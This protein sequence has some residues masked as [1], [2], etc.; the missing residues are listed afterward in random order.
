MDLSTLQ[1][2]DGV[3]YYYI[4]SGMTGGSI[5]PTAVQY[6]LA[7]VGGSNPTAVAAAQ[8]NTIENFIVE[9]TEVLAFYGG[10]TPFMNQEAELLPF[11]GLSDEIAVVNVGVEEGLGGETIEIP[12]RRPPTLGYFVNPF[13]YYCIQ[14]KCYYS[15]CRC[16]R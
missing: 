10:T 5:S 15:F 14:A 11:I 9:C 2:R 4:S 7:T 8:D 13:E 12:R 3:L 16:K 1:S 6:G